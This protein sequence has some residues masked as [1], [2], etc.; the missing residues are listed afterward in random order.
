MRFKRILF[1]L[2][3]ALMLL[4]LFCACASDDPNNAKDF[5]GKIIGVLTGSVFDTVA[6]KNIR[7]PQIMYFNSNADLAV[8]LESGKIDAYVND[9]PVWRLLSAQYPNQKLADQFS[10]EDYGFIFPKNS[11]KS[12]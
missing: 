4:P 1:F 5:N 7:D 11:E 6:E 2:L 10:V 3:T 9:E 8:A 12:T